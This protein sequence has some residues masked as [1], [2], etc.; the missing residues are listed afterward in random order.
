MIT[1]TTVSREQCTARELLAV[2]DARR[3]IS[4]LGARNYAAA[5]DRYA[6]RSVQREA[7]R[8]LA[9][10]AARVA[11][12]RVAEL[13]RTAEPG[14]MLGRMAA[15]RQARQKRQAAAAHK[16]LL[17]GRLGR[18]ALT[19]LIAERTH[20]EVVS[21]GADAL[22]RATIAAVGTI[23]EQAADDLRRM[24]TDEDFS[25]KR[26]RHHKLERTTVCRIEHRRDWTAALIT[27]RDYTSFGS[28][29]WGDQYGSRGGSSFRC[30]LV[31]RDATRGTAHILRVP[32]KFGNSDTQFFG[33]FAGTA[34]RIQAAVAWTFAQRPVDYAPQ[35]TA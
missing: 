3:Q 7:K 28:H 9:T 17:S 29:R 26:G 24:R 34:E 15:I 21:A 35:L 4:R 20:H 23:G 25:G 10:R 32:P 14:C 5:L 30:Y 19:R 22:V 8:L 1:Q 31:V 27:L 6:P 2:Q 16:R 11:D 33:R 13:A 18:A 12:R